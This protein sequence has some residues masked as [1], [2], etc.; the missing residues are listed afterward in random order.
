MD[1][2]ENRPKTIESKS[3]KTP[4][5]R[6]ELY[7]QSDRWRL[8]GQDFLEVIASYGYKVTKDNFASSFSPNE[9]FNYGIDQKEMIYFCEKSI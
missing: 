6:K 1:G 5:Q 8:H 4:E 2:Y 7:G 9:L 3:A